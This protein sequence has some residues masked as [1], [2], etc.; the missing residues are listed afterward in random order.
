MKALKHIVC[1]LLALMTLISILPVPAHAASIHDI[2]FDSSYYAA[3]NPDVVNALGSSPAALRQHYEQYGKREGRAPSNL[4]SPQWYVG[5]YPDLKAAFGT[6]WEAAYNHFVSNG[7]AEGRQGSADFNVTVYK[8]NY[9]DLRAAFGTSPSDNWKYLEHWRNFGQREGRSAVS[10]GSSGNTPA[11]SPVTTPS[12]P[13]NSSY[14]PRYTGNSGSLVTALN[15]VGVDSSYG[16]R[17]QIAAANGIGNYSGTA[18]QNVS[19]LNLLKR[20]T[21]VRP[22]GSSAPAPGAPSGSQSTGV[23]FPLKGGV[24]RSSNAKTNGYYCD[25]KASSGT[26]V[27]AP[28]DGT[29]TLRQTYAINYQKLASYGNNLIFKSSDGV[30]TMTMAHLS[31]FSGDFPCQVRIASSLSYPCSASQYKCTSVDLGTFSVSQ[32]QVI[33]YVGATGNASGPHLHLEV[34]KNGGAVNPASALSAWN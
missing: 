13:S 23:R 7:I 19:L 33:G 2:L 3:A 15:S 8:N 28:A 31:G 12:T 32:G 21:L 34:K 20:G 1:M 4:F 9:S 17:K 6:N 22:G 30:Y 11:S 10:G 5:A 29:V 16:Y 27:Y 14:F 18:S 24:N 25:Y 26:P